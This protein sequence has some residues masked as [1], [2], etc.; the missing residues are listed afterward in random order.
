LIERTRLGNSDYY[1]NSAIYPWTALNQVQSRIVRLIIDIR[2]QASRPPKPSSPYVFGTQTGPIGL[3]ARGSNNLERLLRELEKIFEIAKR[4]PVS[5]MRNE[6]HA[7]IDRLLS[8]PR[9]NIRQDSVEAAQRLVSLL[10]NYPVEEI[11]VHVPFWGLELFPHT[12]EYKVGS[13]TFY[14]IANAMSASWLRK[15]S[16]EGRALLADGGPPG[17]SSYW[18]GVSL[19]TSPRD[20]SHLVTE[21]ERKVTQA[22]ALTVLFIPSLTD[23]DIRKSSYLVSLPR[24]GLSPLDAMIETRYVTDQGTRPVATKR[25]RLQTRT[26]QVRQSDLGDFQKDGFEDCC[27]ALVGDTEVDNAIQRSLELF[28]QGLFVL[29]MNKM[30]VTHMTCLEMMITESYERGLASK[31]ARRIA[32]LAEPNNADRK[33]LIELVELLYDVRSSIVHRGLV[34]E[35]ISNYEWHLIQVM[36]KIILKLAQSGLENFKEVKEYAD[37]QMRGSSGWR[38]TIANWFHIVADRVEGHDKDRCG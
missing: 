36:H 14:S 31:L 33:E 34:F 32:C 9:R 6:I 27:D 17:G 4:V 18:A 35:D 21:A 13:V 37:G 12:F 2:A 28:G 24:P 19:V 25:L 23:K 5:L 22:L 30:F 8:R 7:E 15:L 29:E 1:L 10:S 11:K 26:L 3:S 20:R 38:K 16:N